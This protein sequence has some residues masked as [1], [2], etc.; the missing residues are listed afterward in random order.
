MKNASTSGPEANQTRPN[1]PLDTA[2]MLEKLGYWPI[3]IHPRGVKLRDKIATGKEPIGSKWGLERRDDLWLRNAFKTHRGAGVGICFGP[4]RAPGGGWLIDLEGDGDRAA[5]SLATLLGGEELTTAGW[6]STRGVHTVFTADGERFLTALAAAGGKEEKGVAKVGVWKLPELPDLELRIGGCKADGTVKQV[7][8]VAP[9]T[10]GTDGTTRVW[11]NPPSAGVADLPPAAYAFLERLAASKRPAVKSSLK[12]ANGRGGTSNERR[13]IAYVDK[14]DPAISG[15]R[16]H[17]KTFRA[18]CAVGPGFDLPPDVA[19]R[20]L[21]DRYNPRCEP[22]WS[23]DELRHK[24]EDAYKEEPRRGWLLEQPGNLQRNGPPTTGA[25]GGSFQRPDQRPEIEVSTE[26]HLCVGATIRALAAD[27][28]LYRRGD[29]L[30]TVIE[31]QADTIKLA[32]GVELNRARGSSRFVPTSEAALGCILTRNARYF[33]WRSDKAGE[34]TAAECHPPNWLIAAVATWGSWPGIRALMGI[35]AAPWVRADGSIPDPGYDPATGTLYKPSGKLA[36]I[37]DRP[38]N[39]DAADAAGRLFDLVNDFPFAIA[40]VD[41]SVWLAGLLTAIQ[42]PAIAGPVPGFVFSGNKAG[43]GKGLLVDLIGLI[44][45]GIRIPTRTYPSDPIEAGKIKL[46]LA[47]SGVGAVHFDNLPEGGF[48]G[49]SELDSALTSTIV[50]D[51][52]LGQSRESGPVPLRPVWFLT[53]N[54]ISPGKDAF[55]RWIPSNLQT[56]LE[57]PHERSD[58][59]EKDLR[60]YAMEHRGELLWNALVILKAHAI[61]GRPACAAA[62]LGSFEEWDDLVRGAVWFATGNDCLTN[63][64]KAA[65]ESPERLQKLALLEGWAELPGGDT[66]GLTAAEALAFVEE[67]PARFAMLHG[68]FHAISK[69]SKLANTDRIGKKLRSMNGQNTGSMCFEKAGDENHSSRW[70]VRKL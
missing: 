50:E 4:G 1:T 55:R 16:G 24:V 26:R 3:A 21:R 62:R 10:P 44:A 64:R 38:T 57:N 48:Y 46:S 28:D 29:S 63:Q 5:E 40:G 20:I 14:I 22:P 52:I 9:P 17:D 25:G 49:N 61:A 58:V 11:T 30:G 12:V 47:L 2:L 19:L 45:A 33:Q 15:Q 43:T 36:T 69:D 42:R 65:A 27:P 59:K 23:E 60:R 39:K 31:E 53:G 68:A 56:D 34:S 8:C 13:A 54:N 32:G 6:T 66:Y 37:P 18:A 41:C 35:A 67:Y 51:R 7:Q 70:R